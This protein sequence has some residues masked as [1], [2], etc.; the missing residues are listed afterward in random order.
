VRFNFRGVGASE[1]EHDEGR[2]E[3]ED[4]L[5]PWLQLALRTGRWPWPA[6]PSAPSSPAAACRPWGARDVRKVVLVGTAASRFQVPTLPAEAHERTLV[7]H[8][9]QD[10]TVPLQ[11]C[12]TG[13]GPSHSRYGRARGR[14][15]FH[16]QLP[17]LKSLVVRHLRALHES[18]MRTMNRLAKALLA[19]L[20]AFSACLPP[21]PRC[22]N[23]P[24]SP[25][26]ATCCSTSAPTRS[27]PAATSTPGRAGVA[28]QADDGYL[29]FDALRAK[30][31]TPAA[32]LPVS[33][34]AWKMPG[35]RMFIDPKMQVPVDDLIKGMIVQSG[36]DAT[37]A[38]AEGVGGTVEHFVQLMNEPGQG[39]GHE[40]HRVQEPRGPDR[41]RA[42]RPRRAT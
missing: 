2:G 1:G 10:D 29:V 34:R 20:L 5:A 12:W 14:H 39:A 3:L 18:L 23:P 31:I 42:T 24:R 25:P 36:N 17:L 4:M 11:R 16:G 27:W 37:V 7:V 40:E 22:R 38:L 33:V 13:R 41:R 30:K 15:F 8:G 35:S 26:A 28:D 6:F 32:D 19:P 9:E 21:Q